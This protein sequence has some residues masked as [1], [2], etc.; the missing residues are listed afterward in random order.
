MDISPEDDTIVLSRAE[1]DSMDKWKNVHNNGYVSVTREV[2]DLLNEVPHSF[3]RW[4][5]KIY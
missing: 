2:V 3:F 4:L 5:L 1:Y